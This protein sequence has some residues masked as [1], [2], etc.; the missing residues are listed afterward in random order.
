MNKNEVQ[1]FHSKRNKHLHF[2]EKIV[3]INVGGEQKFDQTA[4]MHK[5]MHK[6][7]VFKNPIVLRNIVIVNPY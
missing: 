3:V 5:C 7:R 6:L 1:W 4:Q 2:I